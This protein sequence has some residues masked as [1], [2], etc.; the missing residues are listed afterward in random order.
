MTLEQGALCIFMLV[1]NLGTGQQKNEKECDSY[2]W[3]SR[4]T[5]KQCSFVQSDWK[6]KKRRETRGPQSWLKYKRV[7]KIRP[8]VLV[9]LSSLA[10]SITMFCTL[11]GRLDPGNNECG[12]STAWKYHCVPRLQR[13]ADERSSPVALTS[14]VPFPKHPLLSVFLSHFPSLPPPLLPPSLSN[15]LLVP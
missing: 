2:S 13:E 6:V 5:V 3:L 9:A 10:P 12:T 14:L 8:R 7:V 11:A 15:K 4:P 1:L